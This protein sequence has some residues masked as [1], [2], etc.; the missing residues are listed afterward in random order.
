[1]RDNREIILT[2]FGTFGDLASNP[3]EK[4]INSLKSEL[5][6]ELYQLFVLP[7]SYSYCSDWS[8]VHI[9]ESTSLVIHFGVS[10]KSEVIQL[11]TT[12]RNVIGTTKDIDGSIPGIKVIEHGPDT[13]QTELDLDRVCKELQ[14]N[15]FKCE[16]SDNAGDYLCNY[17]LYKSLTIAPGKSLFVHIPPEEKISIEELKRF[18]LALIRNLLDQVK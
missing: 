2:G 7:V 13:I 8:K 16:L 6:D 18:T 5:Q 12:G 17:I 9:S 15:C 3:S 1:M 14:K 11:E 10:A 4:L